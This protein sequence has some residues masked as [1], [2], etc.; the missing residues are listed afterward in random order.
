MKDIWDWQPPEEGWRDHLGI[1][2]PLSDESVKLSRVRRWSAFW[3]AVAN[4]AA[5][6]VVFGL[7]A[8][9]VYL[10]V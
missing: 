8:V 7:L 10:S 4:V 9:G 6:V 2:H 3:K 5:W 1:W